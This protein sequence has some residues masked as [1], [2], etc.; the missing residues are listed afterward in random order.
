[1]NQAT[2]TLPGFDHP[3]TLSE[4]VI[5]RLYELIDRITTE[6]MVTVKG[7]VLDEAS[8]MAGA[9]PLRFAAESP[10]KSYFYYEIYI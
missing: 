6:G 9:R 2:L 8:L 3:L 7:G 1:M 10:V 4:K 5:P